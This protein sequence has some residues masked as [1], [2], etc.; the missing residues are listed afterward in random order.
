MKPIISCIL[1]N[2]KKIT[3]KIQKELISID[4]MI[5]TYYLKSFP[6]WSDDE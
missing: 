5:L 2:S 6:L 1:F 3:E 4:K